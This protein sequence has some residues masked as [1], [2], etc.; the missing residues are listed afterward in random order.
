MTIGIEPILRHSSLSVVHSLR[1]VRHPGISA[2]PQILRT[3]DPKMC[4]PASHVAKE[5]INYSDWLANIV[6]EP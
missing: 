6:I 3:P 4:T 2:S 5:H 1:L